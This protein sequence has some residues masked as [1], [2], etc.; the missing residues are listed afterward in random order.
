[1]DRGLARAG[2]QWTRGM[3]CC[4]ALGGHERRRRACLTERTLGS[5]DG[6]DARLWRGG[7]ADHA[8]NA[9][10]RARTIRAGSEQMV[11]FEFRFQDAACGA[12]PPERDVKVAALGRLSVSV[13]GR[14]R[15]GD[16]LQ[17]RPGQVFR[18]L[19]AS[20]GGAQRSEAIAAHCGRIAGRR[21]S[22][23]SGTASSSCAS[24]SPSAAILPARWSRAT[25][26]VTAS[27]CTGS[28]STSTSSRRNRRRYRR[29]PAR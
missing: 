7:E 18:Y 6:L 12:G 16:W 8:L 19:L 5:A 26:P 3:R 23:T 9:T 28:S 2:L 24:S 17:H 25:L 15:D 22:R 4:E 1:M 29:T 21:R 14:S 13:D 27:T 20:R 11:A 10:M